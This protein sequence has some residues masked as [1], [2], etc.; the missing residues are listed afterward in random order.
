MI[1]SPVTTKPSSIASR[2][3]S[4]G[5][6][7][8]AL[9]IQSGEAADELAL[10]KAAALA[11]G[12]EPGD[13]PNLQPEEDT[14]Y[15]ELFAHLAGELT[16]AKTEMLSANSTHLGQLAHIVDLK[17][18]RDGQTGSLSGKF[19][20]ARHTFETLYGSDRRFEVLGISGETPTDPTGLVAQVR[21]TVGFLEDPKVAT[22]DLDLFGVD[23]DPPAMA[24]QLADA[25]DALDLVLTGINEA[26][27]QADVTREAKN[28]AIKAYD[29]K[30]MDVARMAESVF[31]FAGLHELAK[32]VRPSTR[33]PG[34]R[35][36]EVNGETDAT[37][38]Q[39][40]EADGQEPDAQPVEAQPVEAHAEASGEPDAATVD[41]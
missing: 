8:A 33:R 36:E 7:Y 20:K 11:T 5:V 39:P 16:M 26:E 1:T 13:E 37:D 21:E 35:L 15:H 10:R 6:V 28:T 38:T 29:A 24:I 14:T 22:P 12:L 9:M 17:S 30:F 32:R 19:F 40:I 34:R 18:Q 31:R 3:R 2:L 23:L 41:D 4:F 25:A 27:K